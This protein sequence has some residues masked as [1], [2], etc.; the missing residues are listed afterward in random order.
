MDAKEILGKVKQLFADLTA[1]AAP[2][3]PAPAPAAA[4]DAPKEYEIAG[5]GKCMIDKL[6][7]GGIVMIDGAPALPGD[8]ELADGTKITVGDNGVISAVTPGAAAPPAPPAPPSGEDMGAKFTQLETAT[9]EKFTAYEAKFSAYEQKFADYDAKLAKQN[10]MI[11]KLLQFGQLIVDKPAAPADPGVRKPQN[12]LFHNEELKH[13]P[14][15][16]S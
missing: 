2:A 8:L 13:D 12:N 11:E 3:A 10:E 4:A 1:P 7:V 5:G 16:F 9:N 14:A 15:L 6:D